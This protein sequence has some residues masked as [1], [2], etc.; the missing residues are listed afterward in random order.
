MDYVDGENLSERLKRTGKPMTEQEVRDILPQILDALKAV[1]DAGIWHLD[2]KPANIMLEKSGN[3]K[4]IDFGASK[5]MDAQKGGATTSTAISYTNGYAP[6]EQ[7][8][9]N[10]DKFGP[11]TDIYALGA[12]LYNLLTNK[13]PPLPSDIDDDDSADKHQSLPFPEGISDGMKNLVLQLMHTNRKNRPQSVSD[14]MPLGDFPSEPKVQANSSVD[15]KDVEQNNNEE[16]IVSSPQSEETIIDNSPKITPQDNVEPKTA[17]AAEVKQAPYEYKEDETSKGKIAVIICGAFVILLLFIAGRNSCNN[18]VQEVEVVDSIAVSK[19][20]ESFSSLNEIITKKVVENDGASYD[21][22]WLN[23]NANGYGIYIWPDGQRFEGEWENGNRIYGTYTWPEKKDGY[24]YKYIGEF[25]AKGQLDGYGT[26]YYYG[27]TNEEGF[28]VDGEF[29]GKNKGKRTCFYTREKSDII[30]DYPY[31]W[32]LVSVK[33]EGNKTVLKKQ[34][35]ITDS[36]PNNKLGI[37]SNKSEYIEDSATG[38]KYYITNSEIGFDVTKSFVSK[39]RYFKEEYPSL[40]SKVKS[41][42]VYSGHDYY[43]KNLKIR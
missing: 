8:E 32:V 4:L 39:N 34:V 38:E 21:G 43:I 42:N 12:T 5:Q 11:W 17:S 37:A 35:I 2:L 41:I 13:R 1:H 16:T 26:A 7:M 33:L 31:T 40:P 19:I 22:E 28:F 9:Q 27:G 36:N 25:N 15:K 24:M 29:I 10:Y 30:I 23:N 18:N 6:R 14:V 3:I 20:N